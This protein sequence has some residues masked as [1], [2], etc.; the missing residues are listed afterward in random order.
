M[1]TL[2]GEVVYKG[3][4]SF[5]VLNICS[6]GQITRPR[7]TIMKT[8]QIIMMGLQAKTNACV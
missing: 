4:A 1:Y 2:L 5:N 7:K 6:V 3:D 8:A